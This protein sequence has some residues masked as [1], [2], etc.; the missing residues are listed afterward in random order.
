MEIIKADKLSEYQKV[1]N[2]AYEIIPEFYA[3]VIPHEHNIFFVQKFQTAK[4][5]QEQIKNGYE[6]YLMYDDLIGIGYFGLQI[7]KN[8]SEMTLSKLY[9]LK[10]QRGKGFG[11]KAMDFILSRAKHL[12]IV[13]NNINC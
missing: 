3:D 8:N 4:T 5:I 10:E 2:L 13:K 7:D 6:Y 1:E 9:I 12:N 11:S